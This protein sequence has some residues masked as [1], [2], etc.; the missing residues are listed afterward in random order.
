MIIE[1]AIAC[2][3]AIENRKRKINR[4]YID[5]NKKTKDFNYIRKIVKDN[6]IELVEKN[7]DELN[8]IAIGKTHGGVCLSDH[9]VWMYIKWNS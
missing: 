8:T 3:A 6:N 4:V 7:R 9:I 1:G 5:S 2:K